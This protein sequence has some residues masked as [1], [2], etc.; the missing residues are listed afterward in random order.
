LLRKN[1][2]TFNGLQFKQVKKGTGIGHVVSP[3]EY[4]MVFQDTKYSFTGKDRSNQI[5]FQ[6]YC[7]PRVFLTLASE[8]LR[9]ILVE[10]E[11]WFSEE[12]PWLE[13]TV[14]E[15]D[16]PNDATHVLEIEN[17]YADG[18]NQSKGFVL[19]KYFPEIK[20]T[21]KSGCLYSL[22]VET[23]ESLHR[24]VNLTALACMYMAAT[25]RE[26]WYINKDIAA[27]YIRIIKNLTPVPYFVLYLFA[28][29][30]IRSPT[31]FQ[32]LM[33]KLAEAFDGEVNLTWGNTQ[34]MRLR[35]VGNRLLVDGE[36]PGD[37]I[38]I[39]CG[40]MDYPRRFLGKIKEGHRWIA[41]DVTDYTHLVPAVNRKHNTDQLVFVD[42]GWVEAGKNNG[43]NLPPFTTMLM[44]EMIEHMPFNDSKALVS[45]MLSALNRGDRAI[46]TTPNIS[47]N[48]HFAFG[49]DRKFRHDDHHFELTS[50][51]F[52]SYIEQVIDG[53]NIETEFFGIGDQVDGDYL[54]LGVEL[55]RT[56]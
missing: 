5:D 29:R 21:W 54:S 38:E 8:M 47:F 28:K 40:E 32:E 56:E 1:P 44:I 13:K 22:R 25:N 6:S 26:R 55:R 52:K 3:S 9:H 27:K 16:T 42:E 20:L 50:D 35:E 45:E 46:I 10:K 18:F 36:I 19:Q 4:H 23:K 12:I 41:H 53:L 11:R 33:P 43:F 48:R 51:E 34:E 31:D 24:L 37:V 39:G 2:A 30:C 7:N 15:I 17:I 14:D 49:P